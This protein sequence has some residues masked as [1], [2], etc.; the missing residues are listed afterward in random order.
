MTS[1]LNSDD[2]EARRTAA[3][4]AL[5]AIDPHVNG[6]PMLDPFR[7]DWFKAV[8]ATAKGD[9]AK[10][11]WAN[12]SPHPLTADWLNKQGTHLQGIKALDVGCGLGDNAEALSA[13]GCITSAFDLVPCAVEWARKR[14][15]QS[16]VDY[17]AA[18]LFAL[19]EVWHGSF[20]LVHECYTLQALPAELIAP[21]AAAIAKT[22]KPGGRVLVVA[23]SRQE[24]TQRVDPPWPLTRDD[25]TAFE[26]TGLHAVNI[27]LTEERPHWRALFVRPS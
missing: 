9:A 19:P 2:F 7:Q 15:P 12:L 5:S 14:F 10:V 24:E 6:E 17:R 22:L 4:Q 25:L 20:D 26:T 23:R 21:A 8:Y 27:E 13:A 3:R 16:D 11:P 1:D 18:D